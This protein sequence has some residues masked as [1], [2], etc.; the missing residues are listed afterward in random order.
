M[1]SLSSKLF[2]AKSKLLFTKAVSSGKINEFE[3]EIFDKMKGTIIAGLPVSIRIKYSKYLFRNGTCYDRSLY[4]FLGLDDAVLVRG[5]TKHLEAQ[6]GI[7]HEG[8][9][10]V[11]IGDYV[12]DPSL[13]LKFDKETYYKIYGC[14]DI[15]KI[16][17]NTY[18]KEHKEFID[19]N[20]SND[21]NE[22][23]IGGRKR[24]QYGFLLSQ[25]RCLSGF[26]GDENF[27][28]E[29]ED[30]LKEIEYDEKQ[31]EEEKEKLLKKW[32]QD[33]KFKNF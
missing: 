30:Y 1:N 8:H 29:L 17:K 14:Y 6:Y 27:I 16:D 28:K 26:I 19:D 10:W 20:V 23:K 2:L 25:V 32:Y 33:Y 3:E 13:M 15:T 18:L 31:I 4:M 21:Y 11:E 9:G 22:F 12:Y 24:L 7:G 5:R